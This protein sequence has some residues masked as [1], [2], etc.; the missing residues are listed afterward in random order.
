MCDTNP[1]ALLRAQNTCVYVS[2]HLTHSQHGSGAVIVASRKTRRVTQSRNTGIE[3]CCLVERKPPSGKRGAGSSDAAVKTVKREERSSRTV[4][5]VRARNQTWATSVDTRFEHGGKH[6]VPTD[7][8][9]SSGAD[10]NGRPAVVRATSAISRDAGND[11]EACGLVIQTEIISRSRGPAERA[12]T[13]DDR[14]IVD[15]ETQQGTEHAD[16]L[17]TRDDE[18]TVQVSPCKCE[19][20]VGREKAIRERMRAKVCWTPEERVVLQTQRRR[21]DTDN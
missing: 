13:R 3:A 1:A 12:G 18:D 8:V 5:A 11:S 16:V 9:D 19:R 10:D 21:T 4:T 20:G 6:R 2:S 15:T 7:H 17:H 14:R